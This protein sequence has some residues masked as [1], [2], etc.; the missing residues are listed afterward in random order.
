[1]TVRLQGVAV[2][3]SEGSAP[4]VADAR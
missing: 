2:A 4:T 1:V 3:Q